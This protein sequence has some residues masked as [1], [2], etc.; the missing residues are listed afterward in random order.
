MCCRGKINK[1]FKERGMEGGERKKG[2]RREEERERE[3]ERERGAWRE[4][5]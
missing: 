5:W 1:C 3:R 2:G 4:E